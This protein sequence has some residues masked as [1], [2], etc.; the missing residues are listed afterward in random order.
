MSN[1]AVVG[2]GV[3]GAT[4]ALGLRA[5]GQRVTVFERAS[6]PLTGASYNNHNRLHLGFHYPR[7]M[8]TARQS[9]LGFKRFTSAFASC[10]SGSF[11][12]GYFIAEEGSHTTPEDYRRFCGEL[13]VASQ[14]IDLKR[15][16]TPVRKVAMGMQCEEIVYDASLLRDELANR[17]RSSDIAVRYGVRVD[18]IA[19]RGAGYALTLSTGETERF[20]AVVNATYTDINRL[21]EQLGHPAPERQ[22]EYTIVPIMETSMPQI[23]VTIMDG[24]FM[25]VMPFGTTGRSL[26]Y[27]VDLSVIATEIQPLLPLAWRDQETAPIAAIDPERRFAEMIAHS[28]AF[29]PGLADA[30]LVGW[31]AGPRV[32]LAKS[33]DTDARPSLVEEPR[34]NYVTVFSG[35]VDHC[36]WVA[37]RV[38]DHLTGAPA[39]TGQLESPRGAA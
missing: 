14:E 39:E 8:R 18:A 9:I 1:V 3:F 23:G 5:A 20:D 29:L 31:L 33:D 35:K 12:N 36:L 17:L 13:G 32:V 19:E 30:R 28:C 21:S 24:P 26:L 34:P 11:V 27:H 2:C 15:F 10:V 37:D 6:M 7:D 4:I 22:Y 38:V 16:P 25:S